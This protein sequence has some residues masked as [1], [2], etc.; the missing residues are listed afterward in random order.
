MPILKTFSLIALL[1]V[2]LT[3]TWFSTASEAKK[4]PMPA[5]PSESELITSFRKVLGEKLPAT[6]VSLSDDGA[7]KLEL[8]ILRAAKTVSSINDP[9]IINNPEEV[10]KILKQSEDAI[11]ALAKEITDAGRKG[12]ITI[13]K[14]QVQVNQTTIP[15]S[16]T[17]VSDPSN[18]VE[19]AVNRTTD[20][21]MP[22]NTNSSENTNVN[23]MSNTIVTPNLSGKVR[24]PVNRFRNS[25][26][27]GL[28]FAESGSEDTSPAADNSV[29]VIERVTL[30]LNEVNSA[31]GKLCP[32]FFPFC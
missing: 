13:P 8:I 9:A 18:S 17:N 25:F 29:I 22:P 11:T 10:D 12:Q 23:R 24:T 19:T 2:A 7:K 3:A 27:G 15:S 26:I 16:T 28:G 20:S 4:K 32:G 31:Y 14:N 6:Q 1:M 21:N 5:M 30:N